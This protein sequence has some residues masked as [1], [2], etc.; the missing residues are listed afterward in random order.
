VFPA[1]FRLKGE[2]IESRI[3]RWRDMFEMKNIHDRKQF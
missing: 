1:D 2:K 3:V